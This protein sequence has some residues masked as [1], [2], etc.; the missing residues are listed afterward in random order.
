MKFSKIGT[1]FSSGDI[2][3]TKH[4]TECGR[5][6]STVEVLGKC[7]GGY[8]IRM[9]MCNRQ[10]RWF[11]TSIDSDFLHTNSEYH[12]D[13]VIRQFSIDLTDILDG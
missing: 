10:S 1:D 9:K 2:L 8:S 6:L 3:L 7:L 5:V 13:M 4:D 12:P 11:Y